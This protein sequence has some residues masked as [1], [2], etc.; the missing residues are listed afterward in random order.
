MTSVGCVLTGDLYTYMPAYLWKF[1]RTGPTDRIYQG[2]P[3][4]LELDSRSRKITIS[5]ENWPDAVVYVCVCVCTQQKHDAS[6]KYIDLHRVFAIA[7]S[8][9][10]CL[11]LCVCVCV[12]LSVYV[13]VC[14]CCG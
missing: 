10:M 4:T 3:S 6:R 7:P 5:S 11:R 9:L 8:N 1:L 14:E 2:V 12:C 13:C